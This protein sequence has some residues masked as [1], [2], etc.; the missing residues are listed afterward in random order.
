[1]LVSLVAKKLPKV[2]EHCLN[3][4]V[5][6]CRAGQ[7]PSERFRSCSS[8]WPPSAHPGFCVYSFDK[9]PSRQVAAGLSRFFAHR[10]LA[11]QTALRIWDT[12]F[13]EGT[14]ILFRIGLALFSLNSK[15]ILELDDQGSVLTSGPS[16][17][18]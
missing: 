14:K 5:R 8:T 17:C 9:Y 12:L 2:Y 7:S 1:V 15:R 4:K 6:A 11:S 16:L 10:D 18:T 3:M 13:V